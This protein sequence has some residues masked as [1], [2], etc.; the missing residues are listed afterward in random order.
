MLGRWA[1]GDVDSTLRPIVIGATSAVWIP[2]NHRGLYLF[3]L[4]YLAIISASVSGN[5][6]CFCRTWDVSATKDHQLIRSY[7]LI[8]CLKH[9]CTHAPFTAIQ[10]ISLSRLLHASQSTRSTPAPSP[11]LLRPH[12]IN[13]WHRSLRRG[14]ASPHRLRVVRLRPRHFLVVLCLPALSPGRARR[15]LGAAETT[16]SN[17]EVRS[18]SE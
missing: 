5:A 7:S 16:S 18:V 8:L 4:L 10:K 13:L 11:G 14:H 17:L 1:Y 3:Y 6:R 12:R 15:L 2:P 9:Q